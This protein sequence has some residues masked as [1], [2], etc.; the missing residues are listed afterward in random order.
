[1]PSFSQG[2]N[3]L[4][5]LALPP[6]RL[7]SAN[8]W[9]GPSSPREIALHQTTVT[10]TQGAVDFTETLGSSASQKESAEALKAGLAAHAGGH[11][12]RVSAARGSAV[13]PYSRGSRAA[14][15]RARVTKGRVK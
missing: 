2:A 15:G 1:M 12:P 13:H 7:F 6:L 11:P 14:R 8:L 10:F 9:S 3:H 4:P 5:S